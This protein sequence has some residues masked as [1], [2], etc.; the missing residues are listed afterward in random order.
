MSN[1]IDKKDL[2]RLLNFFFPRTGL[3]RDPETQCDWEAEKVY[4]GIVALIGASDKEVTE[5]W[6]EKWSE[7]MANYWEGQ[8]ND[9]FVEDIKQM[10]KELGVK[11]IKCHKNRR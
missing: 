11:V 9:Y 4:Q 6:I 8:E 10:L 2:L 5:E 7:E 1:E 3:I